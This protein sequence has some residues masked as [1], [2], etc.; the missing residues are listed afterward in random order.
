MAISIKL[1]G[2]SDA[3]GTITKI[4][5]ALNREVILELSQITYDGIQ[6]GAGR[7]R[8][9]TG[10]LFASVYNRSI[11]KNARQVGHDEKRAPHAIFVTAGTRPHEIRPKDKKSLR[12][13][14]G[15]R[16]VF[17]K[18]VKHPGYRGDGY[19]LHALTIALRQLP[20][21]TDRAMKG[22]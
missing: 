19:M 2:L 21:I 3:V 10:A 17:A 5:E 1:N 20:E 22:L 11:G 7:H 18:S 13:V 8:G 14:V 9:E 12:W 6:E 15:N 4:P 16:F